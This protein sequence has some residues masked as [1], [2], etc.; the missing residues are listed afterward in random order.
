MH[1]KLFYKRKPRSAVSRL[2]YA[3]GHVDT[4]F[5]NIQIGLVDKLHVCGQVSGCFMIIIMP[6]KIRIIVS[7]SLQTE[8]PSQI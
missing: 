3:R 6:L 5:A 1:L 8:N 4:G 7:S 2:V